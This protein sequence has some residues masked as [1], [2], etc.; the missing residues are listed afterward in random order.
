MASVLAKVEVRWLEYVRP[1]AAMTEGGQKK[2]PQ[3]ADGGAMIEVRPLDDVVDLWHEMVEMLGNKYLV[4]EPRG[5]VTFWSC[6]QKVEVGC[7]GSCVRHHVLQ[8]RWWSPAI[9]MR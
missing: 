8:L 6:R 7:R 9:S 1:E 2:E 3:E 5:R 4:L